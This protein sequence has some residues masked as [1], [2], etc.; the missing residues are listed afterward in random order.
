M[1]QYQRRM[2]KFIWTMN[3]YVVV[4]PIALWKTEASAIS[5]LVYIS[6]LTIL[7]CIAVGC[8]AVYDS[9][10]EQ[11]EAARELPPPPIGFR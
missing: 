1:T 10:S 11:P 4:C 6:T 7:Y 3:I 9:L 5:W 2:T 8:D